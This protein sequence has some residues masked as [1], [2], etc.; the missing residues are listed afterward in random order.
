MGRR[1]LLCAVLASGTPVVSAAVPVLPLVPAVPARG[2]TIRVVSEAEATAAA[3]YWT[4][5]RM[6]AATPAGR[7]GL[8]A[9]PGAEAPARPRVRAY[10]GVPTVGVLFFTTRRRRD[11]FCTASVVDSR[12]HN[13]I[14]T[15]AH[16]LFAYGGGRHH[17]EHLA[18]VPRYERGRAPY[19]VWTVR[20]LY[21]PH[22]WAHRGDADLDFGFATLRRRHGRDIAEVTGSNPLAPNVRPPRRV[23]V[24]GYPSR[25]NA[26]A[27]RPIFCDTTARRRSRWQLT[28]ACPGFYGGTSGSPWLW[29]YDRKRRRG[30]VI[31]VIGGHHAGGWTPGRSYSARFD[32]DIADLRRRAER[33]G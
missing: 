21:V 24:I 14:L 12:R 13:L 16:C 1:L 25:A 10:H 29:R 15:A 27:D 33:L 30:R 4:P 23:R 5:A 19:G 17:H 28:F 32:D 6:A 18:F 8:G 20:R 11:H 3:L 9:A 22:G 2:A 7:D 26:A 31:G